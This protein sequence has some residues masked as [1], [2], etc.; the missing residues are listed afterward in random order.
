M[1]ADQWADGFRG[2]LDDAAPERLV[3][4]SIVADV[5]PE[6]ELDQLRQSGGFAGDVVRAFDRVSGD[7]AELERRLAEL[8]G[9]F[10]ERRAV[11]ERSPEDRLAL[12]E[13]A[14]DIALEELLRQEEAQ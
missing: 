2:M 13:R 1:G 14:R 8:D 10:A 3:W 12:L 5:R 4:E 11:R 9:Q 6:I 7:P